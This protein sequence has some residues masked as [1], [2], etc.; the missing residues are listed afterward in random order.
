MTSIVKDGGH[1]NSGERCSTLDDSQKPKNTLRRE[2][3]LCLV[4]LLFGLLILPLLVFVVGQTI[5]GEF[6]GGGLGVFYTGIHSMLRSGNVVVWFLVLS[7]YLILQTLRL[8]V[9][10]FRI[11][12]RQA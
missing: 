2:A 8:T 9:G 11:A 10:L 4:C 1:L 3:L 5:F 7:P 12:R 6:A